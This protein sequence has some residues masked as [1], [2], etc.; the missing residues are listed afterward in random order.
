MYFVMAKNIVKMVDVFLKSAQVNNLA[1]FNSVQNALKDDFSKWLKQSVS[2]SELGQL[3]TYALA[4]LKSRKI[5]C[6]SLVVNAKIENNRITVHCLVNGAE[7]PI[8]DKLLQ[9][10][11]GGSKIRMRLPDYVRDNL[12]PWNGQEERFL[13]NYNESAFPLDSGFGVTEKEMLPKHPSNKTAQEVNDIR[14]FESWLDKN[15]NQNEKNILANQIVNS[16]ETDIN[17]INISLAV[18]NS[19]LVVHSLINGK[20][21]IKT[22]LM[23][24]NYIMKKKP[25]LM[26]WNSQK[27]DGWISYRG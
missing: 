11:L 4:N 22:N 15:F 12:Q 18:Q 13:I 10:K 7:D 1:L 14:E 21:D 24:K 23:I 2:E 9:E 3:R 25:S 5:H 16:T 6:K 8:C 27:R 26:A 20:E 17:E 19:Q